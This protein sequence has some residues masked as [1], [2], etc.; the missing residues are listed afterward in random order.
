VGDGEKI[1]RVKKKRNKQ[2][3][4]EQGIYV[5]RKIYN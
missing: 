3:N 2:G 1:F 5:Q 4:W